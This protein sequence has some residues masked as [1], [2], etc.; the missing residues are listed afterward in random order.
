MIDWWKGCQVARSVKSNEVEL[1]P[2][3][4]VIHLEGRL[5]LQYCK[6]QS[7]GQVKSLDEGPHDAGRHRVERE[8]HE[9]LTEPRLENR[10][11]EHQ[12]RQPP[13]FYFLGSYPA[14]FTN[15]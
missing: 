7:L 12:S 6:R 3:D 4:K 8:E 9:G 14:L 5:L 11:N 2:S 13:V 15:V 10:I 1:T